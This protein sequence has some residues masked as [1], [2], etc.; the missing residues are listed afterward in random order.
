MEREGRGEE[1]IGSTAGAP[2]G[3]DDGL[4]GQRDGGAE[5]AGNTGRQCWQRW[6]EQQQ[7]R[8]AAAISRGGR[9]VRGGDR[10]QRR[11]RPAL[12]ASDDDDAGER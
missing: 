11:R 6:R 1:E 5:A 9:L 8:K 3:E 7:A 12:P 4:T 10:Q 2:A